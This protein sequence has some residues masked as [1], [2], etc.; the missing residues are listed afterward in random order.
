MAL[1]L[2]LYD[3]DGA[4]MAWVTADPYEY[5][6]AD[7]V[8]DDPSIPMETLLESMEVVKLYDSEQLNPNRGGGHVDKVSVADFTPRE[9]LENLDGAVSPY[10]DSIKIVDE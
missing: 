6:V 4:E 2:Y 3:S 9:Q 1:T 5:S 8:R 10:C 7:F